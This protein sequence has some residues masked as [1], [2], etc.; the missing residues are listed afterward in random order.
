MIRILTVQKNTKL[1][2]EL[3]L[4][5]QGLLGTSQSKQWYSVTLRI[6]EA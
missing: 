2:D 4:P 5:R 1:K 6:Q 3:R